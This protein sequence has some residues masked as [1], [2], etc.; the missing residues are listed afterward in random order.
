MDCW[1]RRNGNIRWGDDPLR[2]YAVKR[3]G[4][5]WWK[6][7]GSEGFSGTGTHGILSD[8]PDSPPPSSGLSVDLSFAAFPGETL[9]SVRLCWPVDSSP[10]RR[11]AGLRSDG[12]SPTIH[13]GGVLGFG[14]G[15][16][17]SGPILC[18]RHANSTQI[19]TSRS[20][21]LSRSL[22]AEMVC[23]N[24]LRSASSVSSG[25]HFICNTIRLPRCNSQ[26]VQRFSC[27]S[28]IDDRQSSR[29]SK[30]RHTTAATRV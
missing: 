23:T 5:F 18:D 6:I 15:S 22:A 1:P 2:A 9:S 24:F 8:L 16:D 7:R 21:P 19:L 29:A 4:S 13:Q 17:P 26:C 27:G 12:A 10:V 28:S 25:K 3:H 14:R 20:R 11:T 30:F